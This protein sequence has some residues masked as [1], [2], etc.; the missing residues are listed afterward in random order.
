MLNHT[1][2]IV[3]LDK[4]L[5]FPPGTK[6]SYSPVLVYHLLGRVVEKTSGKTYAALAKE[7]FKK[8]KMNETSVPAL[9]KDGKLAKSYIQGEDMV[10][11]PQE[12]KQDE[13]LK[14]TEGAAIITTASDLALWNTNLH[15]GKLLKKASYEKMITSTSQRDHFLW[16]MVGYGYGIQINDKEGL[17]ELSHSGYYN[18]F[19]SINFYYPKTGT[20]VIVICNIDW[21]DSNFYYPIKIREIVRSILLK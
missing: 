1:S 5:E 18:G 14:V 2:G 11:K 17:F 10:L 8:C 21:Y 12:L 13:L 4:P 15:G 20:S 7:L 16:G 9:Y 3:E 19:N 6:F